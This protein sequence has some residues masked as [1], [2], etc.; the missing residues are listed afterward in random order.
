MRPDPATSMA[1]TSSS[2]SAKDTP[3]ESSP[4]TAAVAP[5]VSAQTGIRPKLNLQKRT[6]SQAE[7][8][9]GPNTAATDSKGSPFGAAR[10]I[11]TSAREKEIEEKMRQRRELEEKAREEKR[12]ADEKL[13]EEKR[14][15]KEA[16]KGREKPNGS[17]KEGETPR[18]YQILRRDAGEDDDSTQKEPSTTTESGDDANGVAADDK[19]TKPREIVRQAQDLTTASNDV[20]SANQAEEEGWSTVSK[21]SKSRKSTNAGGRAIAS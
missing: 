21:P 9:P 12:I 10:P 2:S 15:A 7:P 3:R 19:Q 4:K 1:T 17:V 11:D 8:S 6:V 13:K 16:E 14:V 20:S 5:A 18:N